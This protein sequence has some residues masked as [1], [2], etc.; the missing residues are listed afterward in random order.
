MKRTREIVSA[1]LSP[2]LAAVVEMY[3]TARV[4]PETVRVYRSALGSWGRWCKARQFSSWPPHPKVVEAYCSDLAQSGRS[5][6]TISLAISALQDAVKQAGTSIHG[7]IAGAQLAKGFRLS[8]RDVLAGIRNTHGVAPKR[9]A[10]PLLARDLEQAMGSLAL[11]SRRGV[12]RA[13]WAAARIRERAFFLIAWSGALRRDEA[14]R[15]ELRDL[16]QNEHEWVLHVRRSKMDQQGRG[17][18]IRIACVQPDGACAACALRA[19][20][21]VRPAGFPCRQCGNAGIWKGR[22]CKRCPCVHCH[23]EG[24]ARC[25][26]FA[27]NARTIARSVQRAARRLGFDPRAFAGHSLRSG[28]ITSARRAGVSLDEIQ[29]VSR[30]TNVNTLLTY[31]RGADVMSGTTPAE[32]ALAGAT[33]APRR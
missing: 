18:V 24:C 10:Q 29:R 21:A 28:L 15:L 33:N 6:S 1:K 32:R 31:I 17:V 30:H 23:G 13:D 8:I 11:S 16:V 12:R 19:W 7:D 25:P 9:Q 2:D 20:L 4:A 27:I 26:L 14:A 22:K 3:R 5:L